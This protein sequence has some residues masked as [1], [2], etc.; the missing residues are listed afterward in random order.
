MQLAPIAVDSNR[1]ASISNVKLAGVSRAADSLP[2]AHNVYNLKKRESLLSR[3]LGTSVSLSRINAFTFTRY[4]YE[5]T[6]KFNDSQRDRL[7]NADD[8]NTTNTIFNISTQGS[9][10]N[11][12]T[13]ILPKAIKKSK[14]FTKQSISLPF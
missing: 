10:T 12:S 1:Q 14:H 2:Y 13:L 5:V 8:I 11:I 9:N 7:R 3:L 4:A 6:K